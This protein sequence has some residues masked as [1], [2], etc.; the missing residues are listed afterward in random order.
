M[1]VSRG[2]RASQALCDDRMLERCRFQCAGEGAPPTLSSLLPSFLDDEPIQ[3]SR[4]LFL[5]GGEAPV[6]PSCGSLLSEETDMP[7]LLAMCSNLALAGDGLFGA[8][9]G[10]DLLFGLSISCLPLAG[11]SLGD[12]VGDK[13]GDVVGGLLCW[14]GLD[15]PSSEAPRCSHPF[16]VALSALGGAP[17]MPAA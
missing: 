5:D 17:E 11:P 14:V 4:H 2:I 15:M 16:E 9:V 6:L 13:F 10:E 3:M 12:V 7:T 1:V 8:L